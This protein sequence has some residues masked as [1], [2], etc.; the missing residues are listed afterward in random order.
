MCSAKKYY[1]YITYS[2]TYRTRTCAGGN[3]TYNIRCVGHGTADGWCRPAVREFVAPRSVRP[4][5]IML[6]DASKT[7][8]FGVIVARDHSPRDYSPRSRVSHKRCMRVAYCVIT[9]VV[10]N[11]ET[12]VYRVYT[13]AVGR[14]FVPP[15]ASDFLFNSVHGRV[16]VKSIII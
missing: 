9:V 11:D 10:V 4:T 2:I 13:H 14:R 8:A 6:L 5:T 15:S 12:S 3:V 16:R 7:I 1:I